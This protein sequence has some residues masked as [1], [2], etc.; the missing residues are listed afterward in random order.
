MS[1]ACSRVF[2]NIYPDCFE[3]KSGSM[4]LNMAYFNKICK[5]EN[6]KKVRPVTP[7]CLSEM[8]AGINS[9]SCHVG[10]MADSSHFRKLTLIILFTKFYPMLSVWTN[11]FYYIQTI[12]QIDLAFSCYGAGSG[13]QLLPALLKFIYI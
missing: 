9:G 4:C 10:Y 5:R 11:T 13:I 3:K 12:F 1:S 7:F 8:K 2:L 6:E